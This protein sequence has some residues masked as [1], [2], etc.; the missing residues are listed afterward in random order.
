MKPVV[1]VLAA[2]EP[3]VIESRYHSVCLGSLAEANELALT[4]LAPLSS[5]LR[6]DPSG[7][8]FLALSFSTFLP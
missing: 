6:C 1:G 8:A 3:Y 7:C 2:T 5:Y 4:S